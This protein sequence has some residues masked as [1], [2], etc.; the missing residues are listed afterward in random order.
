MQR[1]NP[2]RL[3]IHAVNAAAMREL[4]SLLSRWL[5]DGRAEGQ[6]YVALNPR[7]NDRNRG[8]FKINLRSGKWA[9]FATADRGG[10]VMSLAGFL[11]DLSRLE[12]ARRLADMLRV[13]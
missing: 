12:A 10:D 6:E 1:R 11:F 13:R 2:E 9:D 3:D 7:R 8:S 5:P 4:P